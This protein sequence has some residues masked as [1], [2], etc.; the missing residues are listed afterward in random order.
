MVQ[1]TALFG[2]LQIFSH[3]T[4]INS[5]LITLVTLTLQVLLTLPSP[6][7]SG[8]GLSPLLLTEMGPFPLKLTAIHSGLLGAPTGGIASPNKPLNRGTP[9]GLLRLTFLRSTR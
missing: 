3:P 6:L 4:L 1:S 8:S 5:L 2:A 7:S 9:V